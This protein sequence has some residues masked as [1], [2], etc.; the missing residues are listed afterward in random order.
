MFQAITNKLKRVHPR[1][2]VRRWSDVLLAPVDGRCPA[3]RVN[4]RLEAG[5]RVPSVPR[6]VAQPVDVAGLP[7]RSTT[8]GHFPGLKYAPA[9]RNFRGGAAR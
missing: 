8:P 9:L 6:T 3:Q 5:N 7:R 4:V 1:E 2:D